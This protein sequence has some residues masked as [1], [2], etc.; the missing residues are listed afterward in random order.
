MY[1]IRGLNQF[2]DDSLEPRVYEA[3]KNIHLALANFDQDL[4][5]ELGLE[6]YPT[7]EWPGLELAGA[8]GTLGNATRMYVEATVVVTAGQTINLFASGGTVKARLADGG[9]GPVRPAHGIAN[10]SGGIGDIFELQWMRGIITSIGGLTA[11]DQYYTGFVS[12]GTVTNVRTST[13]GLMIQALGIAL[14][15]TTLLMDTNLNYSIKG[16]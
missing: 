10:T 4:A 5:F 3:L 14:D 9:I 7:A 1:L 16:E 11:G 8:M 15:S 6:A 13:A 2:P 12:A